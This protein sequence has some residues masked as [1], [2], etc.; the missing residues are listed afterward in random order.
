MKKKRLCGLDLAVVYEVMPGASWSWSQASQKARKLPNC[1]SFL[2]TSGDFVSAENR[3][4]ISEFG[5]FRN[6]KNSPKSGL[7]SWLRTLGVWSTPAKSMDVLLRRDDDSLPD[8]STNMSFGA[9]VWAF[10]SDG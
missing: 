6:L 7:S 8:D 4:K 10:E 9:I 5:L 2:G 3:M 1:G